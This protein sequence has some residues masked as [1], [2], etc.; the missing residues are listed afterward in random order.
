VSRL[1]TWSSVGQLCLGLSALLLHGLHFESPL[2]GSLRIC[3]PTGMQWSA[4]PG[5]E[6]AGNSPASR[7]GEVRIRSLANPA[8]P[9]TCDIWHAPWTVTKWP[10]ASKAVALESA[11]QSASFRGTSLT[12]VDIAVQSTRPVV[13]GPAVETI[14]QP[15]V[16]IM[17][18]HENASSQLKS[19]TRFSRPILTSLD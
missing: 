1:N 16:F 6:L 12:H 3:R 7:T 8:L 2:Y 18:Q 11:G 19:S 13:F 10:R 17:P 15:G 4:L 5:I 9:A 14:P